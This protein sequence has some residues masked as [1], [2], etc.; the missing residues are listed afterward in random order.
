MSFVHTTKYAHMVG[1]YHC[2]LYFPVI[3]KTVC[4][5]TEDGTCIISIKYVVFHLV[6]SI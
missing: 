3:L 1:L 4:L 5:F 2:C 6:F